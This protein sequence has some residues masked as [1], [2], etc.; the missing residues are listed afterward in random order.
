MYEDLLHPPVHFI[1]QEPLRKTQNNITIITMM[2]KVNA[3]SVIFILLEDKLNFII[4]NCFHKKI[5]FIFDCYF[6]F[7]IISYLN[8][9]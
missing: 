1:L 4:L 2:I 6:R 9:K 8:V 3:Q 7:N 5:K